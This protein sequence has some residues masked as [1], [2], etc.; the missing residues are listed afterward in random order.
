M[1]ASCAAASLL[2]PRW[3]TGDILMLSY[4]SESLLNGTYYTYFHLYIYILG[5]HLSSFGW[6]TVQKT[7]NHI[8]ALYPVPQ[9]SLCLLQAILAPVSLKVQ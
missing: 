5:L 3:Q 1:A 2:H 6:F 4:L 7:I 9:F 8:V